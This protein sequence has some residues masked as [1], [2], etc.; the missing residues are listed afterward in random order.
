MGGGRE[1]LVE[2]RRWRCGWGIAE[3]VVEDAVL[4][5]IAGRAGIRRVEVEDVRIFGGDEGDGVAFVRLAATA[6]YGGVD[7]TG[8]P[9][10]TRRR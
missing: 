8:E 5:L 6:E 2:V 4:V 3:Q 1:Q 7:L 10:G 9:P